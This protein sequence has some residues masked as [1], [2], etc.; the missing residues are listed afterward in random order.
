MKPLLF[1]VALST[2]LA[3]ANPIPQFWTTHFPAPGGTDVDAGT[4]TCIATDW[5]VPTESPS[6]SRST[7]VEQATSRPTLST[8][9]H[10]YTCT[11]FTKSDTSREVTSTYQTTTTESATTRDPESSSTIAPD[12]SSTEVDPGTTTCITFTWPGDPSS[13]TETTAVPPTF[14]T[15]TE[16]TNTAT[17]TTYTES[18]ASRDVTSENPTIT[19]PTI[20]PTLPPSHS[21]SQTSE[22]R[23]STRNVSYTTGYTRTFS[24]N[25][26]SYTR[27]ISFTAATDARP[28]SHETGTV[29]TL[30]LSG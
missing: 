12:P 20:A 11:P 27:S 15:V 14:P 3:L 30:T 2:S 19:A 29:R 22:S 25:D 28:M 21:E 1:F 7:T 8:T 17:R 6:E 4:T 10:E 18:G 24:D 23:Y 16:P 26:P 5:G 13:T 9:Y